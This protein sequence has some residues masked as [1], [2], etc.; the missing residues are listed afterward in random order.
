MLKHIINACV[1]VIIPKLSSI[2]FALRLILNE[3]SNKVRQ[4][5][6]HVIITIAHHGYLNLEGGQVLIQFIIKQCA[7]SVDEN[8]A[9]EDE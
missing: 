3:D 1:S 4:M 2:F 5:I 7:L 6:I 8:D 9:N